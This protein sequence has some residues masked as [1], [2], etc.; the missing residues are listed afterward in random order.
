VNC[1]QSD[2]LNV[3]HKQDIQFGGN[4]ST[5]MEFSQCNATGTTGI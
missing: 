3:T 1:R 4:C 5:K 2:Q